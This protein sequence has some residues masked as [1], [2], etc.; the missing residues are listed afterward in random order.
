M[1]KKY[2]VVGIGNAVSDVI[3][4]TSDEFLSENNVTK[5]IMQLIDETRAAALFSAMKEQQKRLGAQ[6]QTQFRD[7][8]L[9]VLVQ[10]LL[11]G[12]QTMI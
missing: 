1:T 8:A 3:A 7:L 4:K 11:A 12:L 10:L 5:G 9:W 6:W 2:Q